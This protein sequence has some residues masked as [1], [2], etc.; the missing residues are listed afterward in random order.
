MLQTRKM[1]GDMTRERA[2]ATA[3]KDQRPV[4]V[5]DL[6][7]MGAAHHLKLRVRPRYRTIEDIQRRNRAAGFYFFEPATM[8]FFSSRVQ[9]SIYV[10]KDGRAYFVTSERGTWPGARRL[11]TVRVAELSGDINTVGEFQGYQTGRA[12]HAAARKAA[13]L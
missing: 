3:D 11:Y 10:A 9:S 6:A 13:G 1:Y 12:A 4:A 8:R 2:Q 7:T 5:Y